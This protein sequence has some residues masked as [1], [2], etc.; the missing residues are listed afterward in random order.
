M[1]QAHISAQAGSLPMSV[2]FIGLS[3]RSGSRLG[4]EDILDY[5][6]YQEIMLDNEWMSRKP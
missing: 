2:I 1:T 6:V 3:L 5:L 4:L